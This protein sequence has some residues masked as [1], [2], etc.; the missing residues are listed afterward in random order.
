MT[1]YY[2]VTGAPA[3]NS[4]GASATIRAEFQAIQ[5]GISSKLPAL[6]GNANKIPINPKS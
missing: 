3:A 4:F 5:D 1:D 6:T 2:D